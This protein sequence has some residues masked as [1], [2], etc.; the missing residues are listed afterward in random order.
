VK[1]WISVRFALSAAL[2][3]L[4]G[5]AEIRSSEPVRFDGPAAPR[6]AERS[7]V[8][9]GHRVRDVHF[10]ADAPGKNPS[11][12]LRGGGLSSD[13]LRRLLDHARERLVLQSPYLVIDDEATRGIA[14][15][16]AERLGVDV[17]VATNSLAATD[18]LTA[19]SLASKQRKQVVGELR[20][21][22]FELKPV[23][24]E[25][26]LLLPRYSELCKRL[27]AKRARG[28]PLHPLDDNKFEAD[29]VHLSL[30]AKSYV[31]DGRTAWIGSFNLDPRSQNLNTEVGLVIEDEEVAREVEASILRDAAPGNSWTVAPGPESLLPSRSYS[32]CFDLV[33]G[34]EPVSCFAPE[35][36]DRY[37]A[38]GPYP[39]VSQS[40]G[41]V[42]MAALQAMATLAEP[43]V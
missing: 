32:D 7:L 24:D 8:E 18:N 34:H 9:G 1:I 35:F 12:E 4:V 26:R 21:R 33:P 16:R 37:A 10:V 40:V 41:D 6:A 2:L 20:L 22:L 17:L 27:E 11:D 19:W 31:V 43:I 5:C 30:H 23:P 28:E 3:A 39:E 13:A 38:V 14:E 36:R 25:I 42:E 29:G 15:L